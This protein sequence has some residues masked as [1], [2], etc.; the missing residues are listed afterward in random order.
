MSKRQRRIDIAQEMLTTF[1]DLFKN[2]ITG[3]ESWVNGYYIAT[4]A[5]S[6]KWKR[7]EEPRPKKPRQVRSNVKVLLTFFFDCFGVVHHE[8]LPQGLTDNKGYYLE[9][10][11]R[12]RE[13]I[14]Q[15]CT[16][17]W[18]TNHEFCIIIMHQLTHRC[19]CM[20]FWLKTKP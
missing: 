14:R 7:S 6:L 15:K 18:K 3:D 2:I 11:R 4:K 20:S 12:L 8:F 1:N 9:V 19:L 5:Q 17:L 10:L 16:E 13:A